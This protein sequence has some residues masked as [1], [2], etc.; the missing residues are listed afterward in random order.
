MVEQRTLNPVVQGSSP[1]SPIRK[2][3]WSPCNNRT[4]GILVLGVVRSQVRLFV[5][6]CRAVVAPNFQV[7]FV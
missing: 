6:L 5:V 7:Y 4:S 2:N 3:P 1:W